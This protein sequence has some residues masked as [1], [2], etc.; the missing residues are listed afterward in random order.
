MFTLFLGENVEERFTSPSRSYSANYTHA[1]RF[2][3]LQKAVPINNIKSSNT[4][5]TE[6]RLLS[7]T[8]YRPWAWKTFPMVGD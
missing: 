7:I 5:S 3:G 2:S 6:R 4:Q 1:R 8:Q